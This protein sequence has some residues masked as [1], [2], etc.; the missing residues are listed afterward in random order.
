MNLLR[1]QF[2]LIRREVIDMCGDRGA[3]PYTSLIQRAKVVIMEPTVTTELCLGRPVKGI[4]A[5]P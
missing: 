5:N 3:P 4:E 2:I 1:D